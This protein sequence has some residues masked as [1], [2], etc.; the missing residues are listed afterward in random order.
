MITARTSMT[1]IPNDSHGTMSTRMSCTSP[2]ALIPRGVNI[3]GPPSFSMRKLI[4]MN[5]NQIKPPTTP[6]SMPNVQMMSIVLPPSG[7]TFPYKE[8]KNWLLLTYIYY[9]KFYA[10]SQYYVNL[11]NFYLS[12][13]CNVVQL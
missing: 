9:T 3:S 6:P 10:R 8:T 5:T 2:M 7:R 13:I 12:F 1:R 4:N 11:L